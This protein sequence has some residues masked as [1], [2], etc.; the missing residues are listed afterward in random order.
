MCPLTVVVDGSLFEL[1]SKNDST[2]NDSSAKAIV[3]AATTRTNIKPIIPVIC[4]SI[5]ST[6]LI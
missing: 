6:P 4:K 3:D 1:G 2:I 5:I